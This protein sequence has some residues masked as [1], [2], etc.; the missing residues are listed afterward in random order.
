MTAEDGLRRIASPLIDW[1]GR[2]ARHLPWREDPSP[3]HV[4]VSEIMLQQTRV[5]TVKPYYTRF[6]SALPDVP[7]LASCPEDRL[8]K[9]WEGL[10]YYSR[11]RNMRR[12]ALQM[13]EL[14]QGKVPADFNLLMSLPGI[15]SYT[16]GAVASIAFGIP[17][18]AV[19]GNVLRV[20][21]RLL[22]KRDDILLAQVKRD[23]EKTLR[24]V[25]PEEQPGAFNQALMDLGALVC[26]P[27][28]EPLCAGCPLREFCACCANGTV[29]EIPVRKKSRPRR[30]ENRTII[31]LR[32]HDRI[33]LYRRPE[34][35]L[36]AGLY[37]P[38][39]LEGDL[40]ETEAARFLE[41]SGFLL[42]S[43]RK[44]SPTKHIF[45]HIEWK[46][47]GYLADVILPPSSG[48]PPSAV[49]CGAGHTAGA[50][51]VP[52]A[53]SAFMSEL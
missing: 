44:L 2:N 33:L 32:D 36:L 41:R 16:A 14:Y 45:T 38:L 48:L 46:M 18:P 20:V 15:G 26:L 3:Y 9:L 53:F 10:G 50:Y 47:N 52:A 30:T 1:Y 40:S 13:M 21:S 8:M 23:M 19:D 4:W 12:A 51:A 39:N 6:M 42:Q 49:I 34:S 31:L 37:E 7:D 22:E 35:G 43:L 17:V 29:N 27:S 25:I 11:A 28:C 24:R 5:E